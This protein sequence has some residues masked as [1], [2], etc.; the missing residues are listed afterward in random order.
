MNKMIAALLF[1]AALPLPYAY[2]EFLR[3]TVCLGVIYLI[4]KGW[5]LLDGKTKGVLIVIAILFNPFSAIYLSKF[6][7]VVIDVIAGVYLLQL[8]KLQ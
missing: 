4:I 6:I 2:Y 5:A 8:K 3:V 7:W 1:I